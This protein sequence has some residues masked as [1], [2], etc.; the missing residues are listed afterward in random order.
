M[1]VREKESKKIRKFLSLA[2]KRMKMPKADGW[3]PQYL[4]VRKLR[5]NK[6]WG[7][8]KEYK[9]IQERMVPWKPSEESVSRGWI[10]LTVKCC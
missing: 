4:Q 9:Q 3:G 1:G 5:R 6:Q 7:G 2:A 10:Q 8:A